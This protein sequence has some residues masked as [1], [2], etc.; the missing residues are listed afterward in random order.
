MVDNPDSQI[1][2]DDMDDPTESVF[3]QIEE[4]ARQDWPELL[5]CDLQ[6]TTIPT[7]IKNLTMLQILNI[8]NNQL[9][10]LPSEIGFLTNLEELYCG[11]NLFK[12]LPSEIGKLIS[13]SGLYL[14]DNQLESL[15]PSIG[16]LTNLDSLY[17]YRNRLKL[18]PKEIGSLVN[19]TNLSVGENQLV[20]LPPQIVALSRL[21]KLY[22]QANKFE[23]IPPEIFNMNSLVKLYLNGNKIEKIQPEIR[24]L[25]K[26][27][28]LFLSQ[29]LITIIPP[30]IGE[31]TNLIELGLSGNR[32]QKLPEEIGNFV[33]L[34][35][36][37]LSDN[38]LDSFPS[39]IQNLIN[40]KALY[41]SRNQFVTLPKEIGK[42]VSLITLN[43][44]GNELREIPTEL[45][46]LPNLSLLNIRDNPSLETIPQDIIPKG[47]PAILEYLRSLVPKESEPSL[48]RVFG[49]GLWEAV[50]GKQALFMITSVDKSGS[51]CVI[52]G[53]I[54]TVTLTMGETQIQANVTDNNNGTYSVSYLSTK[55]GKYHLSV[56]IKGM[57]IAGS[58]FLTTVFPA[59]PDPLSCH[60]F[61]RGI[62]SAIA[63]QTSDFIIEVK[64]RYGNTVSD[65]KNGIEITNHRSKNIENNLVD[66][67]VVIDGPTKVVAEI[68]PSDIPG[69]YS[70]V[71][72]IP[73]PGNYTLSATLNGE[74][75]S[76][77]PFLINVE[78]ALNVSEENEFVILYR[79][80]NEVWN[81]RSRLHFMTEIDQLA[82]KVQ[83]ELEL[84][85]AYKTEMKKLH[86]G[87]AVAAPRRLFD[88]IRDIQEKIKIEVAA[89]NQEGLMSLLPMRDGLRQDCRQRLRPLL[90]RLDQVAQLQAKRAEWIDQSAIQIKELLQLATS[91]QKVDNYGPDID[92]SLQNYWG[93]RQ[94]LSNLFGQTMTQ[95]DQLLQELSNALK[96]E[97]EILLQSSR[98][99][100]RGGVLSSQLIYAGKRFLEM[101]EKER[102][103][104]EQQHTHELRRQYHNMYRDLEQVEQQRV[105]VDRLKNLQKT[106]NIQKRQKQEE[107]I[108][109]EAKMKL[110]TLDDLK[111]NEIASV[112]R[113]MAE[114]QE[115]IAQKTL[116]LEQVSARM[117]AMTSAHPELVLDSQ[118]ELGPIVPNMG[119]VVNRKFSDYE[120]V[121]ILGYARHRVFLMRYQ[122][123]Y[124][125]LK[126]YLVADEESVSRFEREVS[127]LA[128]LRDPHIV[129]IQCTFYDHS[130]LLAYISMPYYEQGSLRE[131]LRDPK[132][133][134]WKILSLMRQILQG[135]VYLHEHG[136]IHEDL[137]PENVLITADGRPVISD[138]GI[139]KETFLAVSDNN[140]S[141]NSLDPQLDGA[142]YATR[143]YIAPEIIDGKEAT[144]KSDMWSFGILLYEAH[145]HSRPP[146][147]LPKNSSLSTE[148]ERRLWD[149]LQKLLD[150]DPRN[151]PSARKALLHNYFT[152]SVVYDTQ[153][154]TAIAE[155]EN[156]LIQLRSKFDSL[157][158]QYK[159][160]DPI[161]ITISRNTSSITRHLLELY[162]PQN[163]TK[164]ELLRPV[165][166]TFLE[167]D[168]LNSSSLSSELYRN[169]FRYMMNPEVGLFMVSSG[170]SYLPKSDAKMSLNHF[171]ERR[172]SVEFKSKEQA[173]Q[174][175][176]QFAK[177]N[178]NKQDFYKNN[179]NTNENI[180]NN[181]N[182]NE[183]IKDN[184]YINEN[185]KENQYINENI[186]DN[187]YI[188]EDIKDNHKTE[189]NP[190]KTLTKQEKYIAFGRI[191]LKS[192]IDGRAGPVRLSP[193]FL[194]YLLGMQPDF[195]DLE[196]F[197]PQAALI[198][199]NI[200]SETLTEDENLLLGPFIN[201]TDTTVIDETNKHECVN[202][203]INYLLLDSRSKELSWIKTGFFTIDI[204][205]DL[206]HFTLTEL[207]LLIHEQDNIDSDSVWSNLSFSEEWKDCPTPQFLNEFLEQLSPNDLRR[208]MRF[209][210]FLPD[211]PKSSTDSSTSSP[212]LTRTSNPTLTFLSDRKVSVIR[213][214][215][216]NR[217]LPIAHPSIP[218]L[219]LPD[220]QQF[221]VLR[222]RFMESISQF[223]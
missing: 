187:Q 94:Q 191:L 193:F 134:P 154:R 2:S 141:Q 165:K 172:K 140:P 132:P 213:V 67:N 86:V 136:V 216:S 184:Q 81:L 83:Q 211:C 209:V 198:L 189:T 219:E 170:G 222:D 139:S 199:H 8:T 72:V 97:K 73:E 66:L 88:R 99:I 22:L 56:M 13:I 150:T 18:L 182:T 148:R 16:K 82:E 203:I 89:G 48:C 145:F 146:S 108:D 223:L 53:D 122:G 54:Y 188:N 14:H 7:Q 129:P 174:L 164:D 75:I 142:L 104:E 95:T 23:V 160:R 30:E 176:L 57:H 19:L 114:L 51:T 80:V 5:L 210:T 45:G 116:E 15:N 79:L 168:P 61:G 32:I 127:L 201:S 41:A 220:Y 96:Q 100:E 1:E 103:L 110:L 161:Q 38:Q 43:F 123:Q 55:S 12:D 50:V 217:K 195:S 113:Q 156:K 197:D 40:L 175:M 62:E 35:E 65:S 173:N 166:I 190:H 124:C 179:E 215:S 11:H 153:T 194:K 25:T 91:V 87:Q 158:D 84:I 90:N 183:N 180:K 49:N 85:S 68:T 10:F 196:A 147:V 131:W 29:N 109:L 177:Q 106:L 171:Y 60:A 21:R 178:A 59:A 125:V 207:Y 76:G 202:K 6:L 47:T 93:W 102:P 46:N 105:E 74:N 71:Y 218:E 63:N 204:S 28:K 205:Q 157:K 52:G 70:V 101:L 117:F 135:L 27:K 144:T 126:E 36:F 214:N 69:Q 152:T 44:S 98:L 212:S 118:S 159:Q 92:Q 119:V 20:S 64:D 107:L 37:D 185:I 200:L 208:F 169:F 17:L 186:K 78:K 24:K 181:E 39:A 163:L 26:L 128:R 192:V 120:R 121:K 34:I 137:K 167:D 58:P 9:T 155:S 115:K 42:L 4:A 111:T 138:F 151:R 149:L 143:G 31:L 33:S 77:S 133:R 221:E 162:S 206:S 130:R 112:K 3:S